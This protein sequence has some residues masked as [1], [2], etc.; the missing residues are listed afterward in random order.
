MLIKWVVAAFAMALMIVQCRKPRWGIGRMY[1]SIMNRSHTTLTSWGL[2]HVTIGKSDTILD[3]GCGGGRTVQR[4]ATI[5]P[6]G[7][8]FGIDYSADSVAVARSTNK[9]LISAGRVDVQRAS[10]SQLPFAD[11]TFDLVTAVETQYYWPD[12]VN[13]LREILRVLK[14]GGSLVTIA[15]AYKR[16][17]GDILYPLVM[18]MLGGSCLTVREHT[19]QFAEAGYTNIETFEQPRKG[20]FCGIARRSL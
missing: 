7:K 14:P 20:W 1:A 2:E 10:V 6:D 17:E 4:L 13:D 18:K 5:A 8:V 16:R 3:V 19:D 11:G 9:D 15:E 12:P